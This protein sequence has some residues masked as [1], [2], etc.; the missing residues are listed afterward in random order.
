MGTS[1]FIQQI[2]LAFFLTNCTQLSEYIRTGKLDFMLLLPINTRFIVTLRQV[3]LGG[4]VNAGTAIAVMVYAGARL[5][6]SPTLT[7][8]AGFLALAAA[9]VIIHYSLML[10]LA[11]TSFWTVRAQGIVWGYYNLFN[12][13]RLPA[14]AFKGAFKAVFTFVLP[15]LLVANVPAKLIIQKLDSGFEMGLLLA[16]AAIC[17]AVSEGF[18]R[19]SIRRYTSAS[20]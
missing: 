3:D 20:S 16:M 12:I 5:N 19:F 6:L 14:S 7:Q 15:M 8:A 9:S 17:F 13:S 18:W 10:T 1:Q 4:F 11:T 2:F